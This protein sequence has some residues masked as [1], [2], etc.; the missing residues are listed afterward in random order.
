[1]KV[2][3]SGILE[4]ILWTIALLGLYTAGAETSH[5]F[6][7]CP[8]DSLG[9]TWC[10]GCGIGRSIHYFM[11]GDFTTSWAFHPLGGFAFLVIILRIIELIKLN[12]NKKLWQMY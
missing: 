4:L 10:P 8:L 5:S 9:F 6:S 3:N 11:H 2:I 12:L 1:M 7:L